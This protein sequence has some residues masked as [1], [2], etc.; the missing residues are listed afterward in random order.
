MCIRDSVNNAN[1]LGTLSL[2]F[3]RYKNEELQQILTE[4]RANPDEEARREAYGEVAQIFADDV[5]FLYLARTLWAYGAK[6]DV[7]G[8]TGGTPMPDGAG[9]T[10]QPT[11]GVFR[12]ADLYRTR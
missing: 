4:A 9:E 7:G 12:P 8:L 10:G 1:D 11:A 6:T 5:P 2:N 3:G